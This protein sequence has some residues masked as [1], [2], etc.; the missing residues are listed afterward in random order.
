MLEMEFDHDSFDVIWSEGALYYMGFQ[1]AL[2]RCHELLKIGGYLAATEAVYL[3]PDP[4]A[5][6]TQYFQNAYPDIK[7][8]KGKIRDIRGAGFELVSNFTLSKS[9]WLNS[10]YLPLEGELIRLKKKYEGNQ[11]AVGVF[12]ELQRMIDFYR[13]YSRFYSYEF[14]VMKKTHPG[15]NP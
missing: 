14:F 5:P 12:G 13:E 3:V 11:I 4:P 8:V 6:V 7:D 1:P 2:G 15:R 9:T 10:Y